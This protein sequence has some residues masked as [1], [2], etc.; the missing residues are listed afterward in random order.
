MSG[1]RSLE[2]KAGLAPIIV[3][4]LVLVSVGL[5]GLA[6]A[7]WPD[8]GAAAPARALRAQAAPPDPS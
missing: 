5:L 1:T 6:V 4:L 3:A 7:W 8:D 2:S